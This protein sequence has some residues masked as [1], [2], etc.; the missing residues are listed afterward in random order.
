MWKYYYNGVTAVKQLKG[1]NYMALYCK[2]IIMHQKSQKVVLIRIE[3]YKYYTT[4]VHFN[5]SGP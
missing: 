1:S 5:I 3:L 2:V 4:H